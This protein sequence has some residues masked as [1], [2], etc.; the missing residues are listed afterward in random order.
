V[1]NQLSGQGVLK[2]TG[3]NKYEFQEVFILNGNEEYVIVSGLKIGEEI[4]TNPEDFDYG[5]EA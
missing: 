1:F 3:Y 4:I 5:R 2:V